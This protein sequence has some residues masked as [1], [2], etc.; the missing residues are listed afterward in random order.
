MAIRADLF[1]SE[2]EA[3]SYMRSVEPMTPL[4][5]LGGRSRNPPVSFEDYSN[6]KTSQG[7]KEYQYKDMFPAGVRNPQ[8][9]LVRER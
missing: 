9:M 8:E 6:W 1:D 2:S 4:A 7:L 5:T 3:R